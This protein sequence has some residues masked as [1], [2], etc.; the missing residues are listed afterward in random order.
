LR[1]SSILEPASIVLDVGSGSK[2]DVL[3]QLAAP[4]RQVR[5]DLDAG[6]ILDELVRRENES[7]T[8]IADGIA[9]PHARP[10]GLPV[11]TATFGRSPKGVEFDSL[12]G[13]PTTLFVVLVSAVS[14]PEA[15][16]QWLSHVARVLSDEATRRR[17][18]EAPAAREILSILDERE[19]AIEAS[20]P[21]GRTHAERAAAPPDT[22][23]EAG[24]AARKAAH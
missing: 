6:A 22:P 21:G 24:Q 10:D 5:P 20:E 16:V 17:L 23:S 11:V 13:K 8:A 3:A 9:I 12:D 2:R 19:H 14:E 7:S 1:L 4:I 15:H 18:L